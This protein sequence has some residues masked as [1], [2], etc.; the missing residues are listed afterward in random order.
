MSHTNS[1]NSAAKVSLPQRTR[2]CQKHRDFC[3]KY[4][5]SHLGWTDPGWIRRWTALLAEFLEHD[6][7]RLAQAWH[8]TR[9][10]GT[11]GV[12][13]TAVLSGVFQPG[14]FLSMLP[15]T[16]SL[17]CPSVMLRGLWSGIQASPEVWCFKG[18]GFRCRVF[19][20]FIFIW[21]LQGTSL[22]EWRRAVSHPDALLNQPPQCTTG[23]QPQGDP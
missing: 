19:Y 17:L 22:G 10:A 1:H 3:W 2:R 20:L 12:A 5:G 23:V 13:V 18:Q 21:D 8:V 15:R 16:C 7:R 14:I 6:S 11:V 4:P 9:R